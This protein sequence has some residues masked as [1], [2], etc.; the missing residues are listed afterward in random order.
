M[1]VLFPEL[2]ELDEVV[3]NPTAADY[4]RAA[5][6]AF[7]RKKRAFALRQ[8]SAAVVLEP[9]QGAH[10]A[11][12]EEMLAT[13]ADPVGEVPLTAAGTFFGIAA[14]RAWLLA[15]VGQTSGAL[16]VLGQVLAFR[17]HLPFLVWA[18]EWIQWRPF[19]EDKDPAPWLEIARALLTALETEELS[20]GLWRNLDAAARLL[21]A[22]RSRIPSVEVAVLRARILRELGEPAEALEVLLNE[23][24][25]RLDV[26]TEC[27]DCYA[28]LEDREG[29]ARV[30]KTMADLGPDLTAALANRISRR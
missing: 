24:Q 5:R 12:L 10:R 30:R 20:R 6:Y 9:L 27:A 19:A 13:V 14:C 18:E 15:R 22:L 28:D 21:A 26:L 11:L 16:R 3:V 8:L 29:E 2:P 25:A 1:T 4:V 7:G 17:P 23:D